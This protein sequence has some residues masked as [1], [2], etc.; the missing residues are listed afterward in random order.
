MELA[1]INGTYRTAPNSAAQNGQTQT[2]LAAA[3]VAAAA[4][5]SGKQNAFLSKLIN[6]I[7]IFFKKNKQKI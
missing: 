1:I 4:A 5:A 3:A 6:F 2:A 7:L